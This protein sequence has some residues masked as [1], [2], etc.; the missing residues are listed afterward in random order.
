M[1]AKRAARQ[2]TASD[3]ETAITSLHGKTAIVTG[4]A[5]GVGRATARLLLEAG[6]RVMLADPNEKALAAV[7]E[8]LQDEGDVARFNY[9]VQDKLSVAN[10]I[11]ATLDAFDGLDILVN[12]IRISARGS[13]LELSPDD[14]NAVLTHNVRSVFLLCQ[15]VAKRMI[16]QRQEN[17]EF[18]GSMVVVSSIASQRTVAELLSYSVSCAALEQLTRS[19]AASLAAE[20]IR[21]NAVALGSVMTGTLKEALHDR[22]ELRD[23]MLRV[24]PLGRIG[25]SEEAAAAAVFLASDSASFITGQVLGVDGGRSLL[26]PLASPIR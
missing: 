15:Q 11:A 7:Y 14:F 17:E 23:E 4:A 3:R 9:E 13:F 2:E 12:D 20:R 26:D 8:A 18:A 5:A 22:S 1:V 16:L 21:V 25:D 24:T 6:A 10:L 19:M